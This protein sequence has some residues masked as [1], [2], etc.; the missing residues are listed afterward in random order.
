MPY[1]RM[2]TSCALTLAQKDEFKAGLAEVI[3]LIPGK[4]EASLM[5]EVDDGLTMY[6]KGE[7]R[8]LAYLDAK[9]SGETDFEHKKQFTEAVCRLAQKVCELPPDSVYLTYSVFKE[10]GTKGTLMAR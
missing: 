9:F 1:I 10:W 4:T 5:V 8:D 3:G 2:A 6:F 7:R